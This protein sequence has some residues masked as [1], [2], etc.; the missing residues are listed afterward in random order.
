VT[1]AERP[2]PAAAARPDVEGVLSALTEGLPPPEMARVLAALAHRAAVRLHSL[3]RAEAAARKG[4]ADWPAWAQVQNASRTL[5][6]QAST[7]R[8]LAGRLPD[9]GEDP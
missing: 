6:L 3:T 7:C 9:G 1:D 5:V 8:D 4:A 2:P